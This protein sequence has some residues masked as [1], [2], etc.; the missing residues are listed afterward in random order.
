[1][2]FGFSFIWLQ[3]A[4]MRHKLLKSAYG[5]IIQCLYVPKLLDRSHCWCIKPQILA[6]RR[7]KNLKDI[8]VHKKHNS[9]FFK[10]EH[11]CEPAVGTVLFVRMFPNFEGKTFN[12]KNY[13]NCTTANEVYALFC[14]HCDKCIYVGETG[15]TLYQ[16]HLLNL[17]LIRRQKP[18]P[19]AIYFNSTEHSVNDYEIMALEKNCGD[20]SYR[21]SIEKL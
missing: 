6:F 17:S 15:D 9:L 21:E 12:V 3:S 4:L 8:I 14:K 13:F 2:L 11:K 10:Q 16:R 18:D 5:A 7:D 20:N 19:I 1:M